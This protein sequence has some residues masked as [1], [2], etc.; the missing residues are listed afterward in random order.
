MLRF[1]LL[2]S[3]FVAAAAFAQNN[4]SAVS[5]TGSDSNA[6]TVVSPCRSFGVA[7]AHTNA[8]GEVI[9]ID[10]GGY[11]AFAI[12]QAVSVIGAPGI[13]AAITA[14]ADGIGVTAASI[15]TVT[16]RGLNITLTT[17]SKGI[18]ATSFG[19]LFIDNCSVSGGNV[20]I[21]ISGSSSSKASI[22]DSVVRGADYG[23]VI[24]SP[25]AMLR[26]RGEAN[27]N[28]G[29]YVQSGPDADGVV[30]A[31]D[32][33]A[34]GNGAGA[35]ADSVLSG[36]QVILTLDHALLFHNDVGAYTSQNGVAGPDARVRVTNCT[37]TENLLGLVQQGASEFSSMN[38]NLVAGNPSGDTTGTISPI[39]VH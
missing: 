36:H 12:N 32:F 31:V 11:G 23:F 5:V 26:C 16:I 17:S 29:L 25:V 6:C 9:A 7:I 35:A 18:K 4:R 28:A 37:V 13:H 39:T 30:A 21:S 8:G 3:M 38:N 20:G 15:D 24:Q 33:V 1:T 19:K 27:S 14:S 22:A 34:T 10:S 2:I